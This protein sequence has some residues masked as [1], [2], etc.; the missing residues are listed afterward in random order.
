MHCMLVA[1]VSSSDDEPVARSHVI[2]R[3]LL[4]LGYQRVVHGLLRDVYQYRRNTYVRVTVKRSVAGYNV[5][6]F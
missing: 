4:L 1:C 3:R 5:F 6:R 2:V